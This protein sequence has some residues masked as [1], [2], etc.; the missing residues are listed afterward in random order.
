MTVVRWLVR[1]YPRAFRERWGADLAADAGASDW[2]DLLVG[3]ADAWLH[4]AVWPARS[5]AQRQARVTA[6]AVIVTGIGW[7]AVHLIVEDGRGLSRVLDVCAVAVVAGLGL[8]A[9]RPNPATLMALGRRLVRGLAGPAVLG[10]IV[11]AVVHATNGSFAPPVRLTL[12]LCWWGAWGL[13]VIQVGRAVAGIG[14]VPAVP[15]RRFRLGVRVLA[16][17]AAAI[18]ATQLVAGAA[19]ALGLVLLATPL[20]L[21]TP[22][23][24]A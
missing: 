7:F 14:P 12:L 4:P 3:A 17:A 5:A 9:P 6:M 2:A 1:L 13:A 16:T 18:G 22:E 19:P 23:T 24:A 21:R 20:V 15:P 8:V 11:V 10:L